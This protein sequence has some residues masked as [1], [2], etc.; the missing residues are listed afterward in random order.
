MQLSEESPVWK[1]PNTSSII[2]DKK[3]YYAA[4]PFLQ[5]R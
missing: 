1:K 5:T 3:S 4:I 2:K